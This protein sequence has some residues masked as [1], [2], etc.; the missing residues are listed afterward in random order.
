MSD[1]I[2][3][4]NNIDVLLNSEFFRIMINAREFEHV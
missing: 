1:D 4:D 3:I 2:D